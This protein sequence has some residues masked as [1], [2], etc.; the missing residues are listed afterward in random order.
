[1]RIAYLI[2]MDFRLSPLRLRARGFSIVEVMIAAALVAV[3]LGSIAAMAAK[4]LHTLRSTRQ[5]VAASHLL[6]QRIEA[7]RGK[8]WPEMA[9]AAALA[10]LM[11]TPV[12]SEPEL[13]EWNVCETVTVR[14]PDPAAANLVADARCFTVRRQRGIVHVDQDGDFGGEPTLLVESLVTWRDS[15]GEHERKLRT[16]ICRT[17]L[18]RSGVFGSALGRPRSR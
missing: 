18:T 4:T 3:G 13:A 16:V 14:V 5:V 10:V 12:A 11:Q 8:P 15:D 9:N 1:M 2:A 7:M 6:Q 17:G